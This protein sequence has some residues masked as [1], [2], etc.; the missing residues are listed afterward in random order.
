M[1]NPLFTWDRSRYSPAY[2]ML[3][4]QESVVQKGVLDFL[5]A[6]D[7]FAFAVD[8]GGARLR[9]RAHAA[10]LKA[11]GNA[12]A[13]HGAAGGSVAGIP[14][15]IGTLPS[16]RSIYIECK[17]PEWLESFAGGAVL[18]QLRPAG[19]LRPDQLAFLTRAEA[20]NALCIVAWHFTDVER[21]LDRGIK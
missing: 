7:I 14:D 18:R 10:I 13:L 20:S 5:A 9:G 1:T 6:R 4:C 19:K 21:A 8:A 12:G 15:I 16:G 17:R 2:L 3:G 11:G